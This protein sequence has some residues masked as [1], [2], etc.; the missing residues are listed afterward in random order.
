MS[1]LLFEVEQDGDWLVATCHDPEMATQAE[2]LEELPV[3]IRDLVQCRFDP[4]DQRL[5][6]PISLHFAKDPQLAPTA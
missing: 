6:W 5:K 2:T 1:K 4:G 3:M